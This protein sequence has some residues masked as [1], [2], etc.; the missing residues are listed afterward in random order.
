MEC[1]H[2]VCGVSAVGSARLVRV[3]AGELEVEE[4]GEREVE[5]V[6]ERDVAASVVRALYSLEVTSRIP[7]ITISW[8]LAFGPCGALSSNPSG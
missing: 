4:G 1:M 6:G 5:V 7:A 3:R 8:S 2:R